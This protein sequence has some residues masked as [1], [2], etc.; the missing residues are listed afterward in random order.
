MTLS[1]FWQYYQDQI[2]LE[3]L[4]HLRIIIIGIPIAI[5]ISVPLGFYISSRPK[6]ARH[7]ININSVLMTIPSLALFGIMVAI[8]SLI[9]QGLGLFPAVSSIMVYSLLPITRNTY[10]AL[11]QVN[12]EVID[13]AIGIGMSSRRIFWEIKV[14]LS[15]P[16]IM[17]GIRNAIVMG[18]GVA[19]YAYLVAAGGL[20]FFIFAGIGRANYMM[21]GTGAVIVSLLGISLNFLFLKI[22]DII[23]PKGLKIKKS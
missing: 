1:L 13:A 16:T 6:I 23:T 8:F 12:A 14:P 11:N 20:G 7:V 19:T 22:E 9:N 18:V 15:I 5:L 2:F 3:L 21:I 17:A 10:L 4:Q